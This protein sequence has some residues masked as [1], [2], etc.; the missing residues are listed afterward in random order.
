MR[1]KLPFNSEDV[2]EREAPRKE[3]KTRFF[4]FLN[5]HLGGKGLEYEIEGEGAEFNIIIDVP[6][7]HFEDQRRQMAGFGSID[8]TPFDNEVL[9][10]IVRK[11]NYSTNIKCEFTV[12]PD[13]KCRISVSKKRY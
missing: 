12:T 7:E 4:D 8:P 2:P 11:I 9:L 13:K 5:E 10:P 3:T 6:D 1:E